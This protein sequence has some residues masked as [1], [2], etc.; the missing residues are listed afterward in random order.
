VR[1]SGYEAEVP[2]SALAMNRT[3]KLL[4]GGGV[5]VLLV[6]AALSAFPQHVQEPTTAE[7]AEAAGVAESELTLYI[8]VYSA[9]QADHD[10]T[11]DAALAARQVTLDHFRNIEQRVQREQRLVDRVRQ[12]LLEQAKNRSFAAIGSPQR[13]G[14]SEPAP[15]D[16][17]REKQP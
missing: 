13:A 5:G 4:F 9:M 16:G 8:D 1:G 7:E 15:A 10:L 11:I 6:T 17:E 14:G 2:I 12:A 3:M